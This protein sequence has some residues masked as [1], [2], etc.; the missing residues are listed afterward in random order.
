MEELE[1]LDKIF[2]PQRIALVG[3]TPNPKSVGGKILSNLITGG[4]RGVVYPVNPTVEAVMGIPCFTGVASLPR[5]PDLAV[6]CT[7][8]PQVPRIVAEC[9]QAGITGIIIISAGFRETGPEGRALEEQ[10]L[11]EK[12]KY[13]GMR[14]L[15]PNC[16]GVISP[17]LNLNASFAADMPL[18]GHI[19]FISQSGALCT[20]ILD[21]SLEEKIGF[22]YFVS[23]GNALDIDFGDLIDYFGEDENTRSIL[24]YIESISNPRRFMSAARAYARTKPIIAYKAGRFPESAE[25]A[26]SHTGAMAAEDA[27]Y[28]AAFQRAGMARVFEIGEMFDVAELIGRHKIPKG[29]RLAIVTNAG[30]PGV[31][32]SDALIEAG[33]RLAELSLQTVEFLDQN[34]PPAWSH[35]NPVDV[36][37]DAKSKT[38]AKAVNAVLQDEGVDAVLL[39]I[40]PQAMTNPPGI[41]KELIPIAA[42]AKKP[43]LAAFLGG[44]SMR[45]GNRLLN[46]AGIPTY[47]TPEQA[48]RAFMILVNYAR[49]LENLYETPREIS[50]EFPVER[51]K[52]REKVL[53]WLTEGPE[54][55][56]EETSKK[57]ID[58][59]GIPTTL[60]RLARTSEEAVKLSREIGYPVVLKIHSPDITHKT[61]VG[62]VVLDLE[63]DHMVEAAYDRMMHTVRERMPEA[64]IEGVVVQKMVKARDALEMIIGSKK[65]PTFGAVI[66]VGLG[67]T[68]AEVL[69]DRSI[70]FP[71]LNER[72]ARRALE[73]LKSWPL[74]RGYRGR[75][76][77][78]IDRLIEIII[79]FSYLVADYPEIKEIDINP[80]L[81]SPE[82]VVALDARIIADRTVA[83]ELVQPYQHLVLR[84][85]PEEFIRKARMRD[86]TEITL[87]PIR[88]EDE[89]LWFELLGSCSRETIYSRFRYFFFWQSHEVASR[90]CYIDYDREMAIVA[91]L[92]DGQKRRIL[93]VGRLTADPT[94]T[95]AEYA[96]LVQDDWQNRG[97]GGILTDYC[98]EIARAWG[99]KKI[100]AYT[101]T[102]NPRMIAVF[103]KRDFEIRQDPQSTLV[104]IQKAL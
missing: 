66:M 74:L 1:T 65:D 44:P 24:M 42:E 4:Y 63:D 83:P 9:G 93:G 30:G 46:E 15:G 6:I 70:C 98:T 35:R 32:A 90:Y 34:L 58:A 40:T 2:K 75:P 59:Y 31:M 45:E 91:E 67:G 95:V 16:L 61:D 97:L 19:A 27:I 39:I 52:I 99:V 71:P 57:I 25:A 81:V 64:R 55:L 20:S 7:P 54:V 43:V 11:A 88:P 37:G 5:T 72:L 102:D 103:K 47:G 69:K 21:W 68:A 73:Q 60:P 10:I 101:T 53:P 62:G 86:G 84:P 96:V 14:I 22:S 48:V 51:E 80:L 100:I 50:V 3:V 78:N 85:Y 33:G 79:R 56:S 28:E 23:I 18:N 29:P 12:K 92:Q 13:P 82:E 89:P 87:R 49:N 38:V 36:L 41:A 76:P 94:R 17:G 26:S 77:A 8:A 104:E